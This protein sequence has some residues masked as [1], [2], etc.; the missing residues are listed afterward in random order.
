MFRFIALPL[1]RPSIVAGLSL[2]L[3]ETISDFGTVEYFTVETLTLGIFNVWL[4]Q[5]SLPAAAQISCIAFIFIIVLI[6]LEKL[7]RRRR[8]YTDTSS[9]AVSLQPQKGT[10]LQDFSCLVVCATPIVIGFIIPVTVI[11]GRVSLLVTQFLTLIN[12]F[13]H[14]MVSI[15][16]IH[17]ENGD[18]S[19][20]P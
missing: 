12:L 15:Y 6:I 3:M 1:A 14:Q 7:A 18:M 2:A 20:I 17:I 8:R 13:I 19:V 9:K 4:G 16:F 11:P 10:R 5:N